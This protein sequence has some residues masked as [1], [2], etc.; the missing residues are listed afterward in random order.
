MEKADNRVR[1]KNGKAK[2]H[3]LIVLGVSVILTFIAIILAA[4]TS[5][6]NSP[7]ANSN[8]STT[9]N[10]SCRSGME[11]A[12]NASLL[13]NSSGGA[14]TTYLITIT[15]TTGN[16]SV[17]ENASVLITGLTETSTYNMTCL[18]SNATDNVYSTAVAGITIDNTPPNASFVNPVNNG[19][20]SGNLV[21]N[22]SVLDSL[23]GVESVYFNITNSSGVQVNFTKASGSG[24]YYNITVD[25][26]KFIDGKYNIT[27]YAN[28]TELNNL[29]NTE[30]VQITIDN[31]NPLISFG[32]GTESN[33]TAVS[34]DWIYINVSVTEANEANI[35]FLLYNTTG[36]VNSTTSAAGTRTINFTGLP[37]GTY[38]YNVTITDAVNKKNTTETRTIVLDTTAPSITLTL[39]SATKTSL[40]ITINGAEGNCSVDSTNAII[41]GSTLT[42]GDLKCG[43][44]YT[45]T[46]SCTDAAGNTGTSPATSFSTSSCGGGGG[47]SSSSGLTTLLWR[48]TYN[49]LPNQLETGYTKKLAPKER[50]KIEVNN[51]KHYLGI[52]KL[53]K[54]T[55]VIE[56]SSKPIEI[57]LSIGSSKKV[58]VNT[59]GY[60]D[61]YVKLNDI[62]NNK[63]D[64]TVRKIN[65]KYEKT[66]TKKSEKTA[67]SSRLTGQV[68]KEDTVNYPETESKMSRA[69]FWILIALIVAAVIA[70]VWSIIRR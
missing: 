53:T 19:N 60:Y 27:V 26:T 49:P 70:A 36:Q 51:E 63:A 3:A 43:T 40:T 68:T 35:T 62:I 24:G 46:V 57:A 69:L 15:N 47:S 66:S 20:Y 55:A 54:T 52:K 38:T 12:L 16:Q 18:M 13:Y 30:R 10:F 8:Y 67:G 56:I 48:N 22:A 28:D 17:F 5:G 34:R 21:V 1:E 14:A 44:S 9:L 32:T 61:L 11:D 41:S 42:Q 65:E 2:S 45:Y 37:D 50:I 4:G 29:N 31:T 23:I 64:I 7:I 59:D 33:G 25:T 6:L 39:S 58:D